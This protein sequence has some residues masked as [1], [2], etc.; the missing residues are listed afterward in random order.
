MLNLHISKTPCEQK[1][2]SV[3]EPRQFTNINI[4]MII[5]FWLSALA[6][7]DDEVS[8]TE[9]AVL[10]SLFSGGRWLSLKAHF[11]SDVPNLMLLRKTLTYINL[12]FNCFTEIPSEIYEMECLQILKLRN[13]PISEI[14]QEISKL[15]RLRVLVMSF[16]LVSSISAS[17]WY[18]MEKLILLDLSFNKLKSIPNEILHLK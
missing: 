13:N 4:I 17:F 9:F 5:F 7:K 3:N 14:P 16:C 2:L 1:N 15:K 6:N 11:I 12:S 18:G 8:P 10:E